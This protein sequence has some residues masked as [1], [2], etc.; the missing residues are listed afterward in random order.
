[1]HRAAVDRE[2]HSRTAGAPGWRRAGRAPRAPGQRRG[3][4]RAG[5]G[6]RHP[7][8][9]GWRAAHPA[10]PA[11]APVH[12]RRRPAV[13]LPGHDRGRHGLPRH[14]VRSARGIP[15][16]LF[17]PRREPGARH[18]RRPGDRGQARC[19]Q[20]RGGPDPRSQAGRPGADGSAQVRRFLCRRHR[21]ARQ[22]RQAARAPQAVRPHRGRT[23]A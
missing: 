19:A 16:R 22:Q 9:R 5:P 3:Q 1:G 11:L 6:Q 2:P 10:R 15:Q 13:A 12:H 20:R 4:P 23:G 8:H 21:L 7:A 18:A 14:R 17:H